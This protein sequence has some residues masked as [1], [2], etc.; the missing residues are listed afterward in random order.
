[1]LL[2][3]IETM[4]G[5]EVVRIVDGVTHFESTKDS[6]YKIKL[7]A[8]ENILM[9]LET[10][11]KRAL[12]VKIADRMHNMRT[13]DGHR[14]YAKKKQ[15]AEETLQFFVPLAKELGLN[16][17]ANELKERSMKVLNATPAPSANNKKEN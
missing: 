2:E 12:Y 16:E 5:P 14:S 1:M 8:H 3:N 11:E 7:S 13:I 17:A 4:F 15:I 10:E 9:L 6:F